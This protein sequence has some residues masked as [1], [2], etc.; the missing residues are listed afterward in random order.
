MIAPDCSCRVRRRATATRQTAT[1]SSQ[2]RFFLFHR[3]P[4]NKTHRNRSVENGVQLT[5]RDRF[6]SHCSLSLSFPFLF[7]ALM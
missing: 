2:K 4:E 3:V 7:S 1:S 5:A 6:I